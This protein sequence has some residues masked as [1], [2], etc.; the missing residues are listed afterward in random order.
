MYW[1][2]ALDLFQAGGQKERRKPAVCPHRTGRLVETQSSSNARRR[3]RICS[4]VCCRCARQHSRSAR[5]CAMLLR[6]DCCLLLATLRWPAL[7]PLS[8]S[9]RHNDDDSNSLERYAGRA[10]TSRAGL[11]RASPL[12]NHAV[13]VTSRS[14]PKVNLVLG[15]L[16]VR[17]RVLGR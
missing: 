3:R 1:V 12:R 10:G 6:V 5:Y 14:K 17:A 9:Y 13:K 7:K 11:R 4:S 8:L 2:R 15:G 16:R